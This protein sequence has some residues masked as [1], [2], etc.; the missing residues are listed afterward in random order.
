MRGWLIVVLLVTASACG[1]SYCPPPEKATPGSR[2]D[3]LNVVDCEAIAA[4]SMSST[5]N[6]VKL[7]LLVI[8]SLSSFVG[9]ILAAANKLSPMWR[10]CVAGIPGVCAALLAV[11]S[12]RVDW[13][14]SKEIEINEIAH[15]VRYG[16]IT[17]QE[18]DG[19]YWAARKQEEG[20]FQKSEMHDRAS[21]WDSA[22]KR[23]VSDSGGAS[24][25]PP[26]PQ[27]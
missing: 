1:K 20:S 26:T 8:L 25:S 14:R 24:S 16:R 15:A 7:S 5:L 22:R 19:L 3:W 12:P 21:L 2:E 6:V 18:G 4:G 10:A 27:P 13:H 11:V 23:P 9:T 17:L